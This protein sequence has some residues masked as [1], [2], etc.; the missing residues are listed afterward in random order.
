MI[1][2][3]EGDFDIERDIAAVKDDSC[4]ATVSFVGTVKSP[5]DGVEV[6]ELELEA[7]GEMAKKELEKI[8]Q[9][10]KERF[11]VKEILV[12]HRTGKL[13]VGDNIVHIC[14]S[15]VGR[16]AAFDAARF[17]L[18][19]LKGKVPIFKKESKDD[20]VSWHG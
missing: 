10:A 15:S 20:G 9:A 3:Q 1:V 2:I 17:I 8:E 12:I 6:S 13:E 14:V 19:E 18:E 11:G 5:V 7:Y 16:D 4:G